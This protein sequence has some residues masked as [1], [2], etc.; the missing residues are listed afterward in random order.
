[1]DPV[2]FGLVGYGF[3]GRYF[4]APLIASAGECEFL[5]VVTSS[6]ERRALVAADHPG[7]DTF[8]S[9]QGLAAAGAEAVAISTPADTHSELTDAAIELGLSVVCDK[10]FALDAAAAQRSVDLAER[11]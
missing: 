4:H 6:S 8:D 9:L 3:G 5:G 2:K 10:P 7:L 1:M 11:L